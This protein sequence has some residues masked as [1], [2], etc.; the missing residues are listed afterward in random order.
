MGKELYEQS[1]IARQLFAIA[2][3]I[4]GY[5]IA[6]V[7]FHGSEEDLKRTSVTQPAIYLHSVAAALAHGLEQEAAAVAG[8]SLGEFSALAAAGVFRFEDGLGL[9]L[10]RATAMQAACDQQDSAMAAVL[11]MEDA[12][13]EEVC[14]SVQGEV[15]V[16]ANYNT[17]GQLV[18]SG[19]RA[20]IAQA[21]ELL[22]AR[23]AS[24]VVE[25]PV[26]GA[27]HSPLMEPARI[28]LA[29]GIEQTPFED[30]RIPVYQNVTARPHRDRGEIRENLLRQLTAPVRWTQTVQAMQADGIGAFVEAGPGKVLSGLIK[31]VG[32]QLET[33]QA[34]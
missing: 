21:I 30:A 31:K 17:V 24:R 11:G 5:D 25:L 4:L 16:P 33:S 23:G 15:V 19:S 6:E 13:V 27:F 12:V 18:I 32:R 34:G 28:E 3:E 9:V 10:T 26:N 20:G 1:G 7:M 22:K 14:A 8:H 29:R 2:R